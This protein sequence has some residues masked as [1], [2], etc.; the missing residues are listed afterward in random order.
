MISDDDDLYTNS[1]GWSLKNVLLDR[2]FEWSFAMEKFNF[3]LCSF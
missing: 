2:N 3:R 1:I